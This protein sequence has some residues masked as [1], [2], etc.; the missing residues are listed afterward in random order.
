MVGPYNSPP[1]QLLIAIFYA[2]AKATF[3]SIST[4]HVYSVQSTILQDLN[5]LTDVAREVATASVQDDPLECGKQWGM[6]QNRHVKVY[7]TPAH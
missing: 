3:R 7:C 2:D 4:I 6:I 1:R 5:V